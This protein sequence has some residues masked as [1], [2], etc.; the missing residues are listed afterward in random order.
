M[1]LCYQ[2]NSTF[3]FLLFLLYDVGH[4]AGKDFFKL[5]VFICIADNTHVKEALAFCS[6]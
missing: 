5:E 4:V 1:A 2:S 3:L 6:L